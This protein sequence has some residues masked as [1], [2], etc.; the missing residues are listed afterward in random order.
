MVG[1]DSK[2]ATGKVVSNTL[3]VLQIY[4][5]IQTLIIIIL[6]SEYIWKA[7][8]LKKKKNNKL[9]PPTCINCQRERSHKLM[10]RSLEPRVSLSLSL[11]ERTV[12]GTE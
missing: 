9:E 7:F 4:N 8:S 6:L 3:R 1:G 10:V 12:S 11:P 5:C 2:K